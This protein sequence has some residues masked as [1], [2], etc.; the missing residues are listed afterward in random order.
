MHQPPPGLDASRTLAQALGEWS[1]FGAAVGEVADLLDAT[2]AAH[3]ALAAEAAGVE[4]HASSGGLAHR[5]GMPSEQGRREA[6]LAA[7]DEWE[8]RLR[9]LQNGQFVASGDGA[10]RPGDASFASPFTSRS[11][12]IGAALLVLRQGRATLVTTIQMFKVTATT[13][14]RARAGVRA[15][16][17]VCVWQEGVGARCVVA[18]GCAV[19]AVARRRARSAALLL[20]RSRSGR[21]L[22]LIPALSCLLSHACSLSPARSLVLNPLITALPPRPLSLARCASRALSLPRSLARFQILAL[23]CLLSAYGLSVLYLDGIKNGD[24]QMTLSAILNAAAFLFISQAKPM[25]TLSA[26]RPPASV[27]SA[28]AAVSVGGQF[29]CHLFALVALV[30]EARAVPAAGPRARCKLDGHSDP[31]AR[32]PARGRRARRTLERPRARARCAS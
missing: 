26:Q 20:A 6:L 9:E 22:A 1:G 19:L 23:N 12:S 4:P 15:C 31:L 7:S 28:Y 24:S 27:L 17:R 8:A 14:A 32:P 21:S 10:V 29:A 13:R 30:Q 16:E 25:R 11:P 3:D 5:R 2:A 18:R